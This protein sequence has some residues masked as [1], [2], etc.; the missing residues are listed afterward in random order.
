MG[1]FDS[2]PP[3]RDDLKCKW[4]PFIQ[5]K[6][7]GDQYYANYD[8]IRKVVYDAETLEPVVVT[9]YKGWK[10]IL[11]RNQNNVEIVETDDVTFG[12]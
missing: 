9:S 11:K 5:K 12:N 8:W 2:L 4:M 7:K 1:I 3:A 10:G 6:H